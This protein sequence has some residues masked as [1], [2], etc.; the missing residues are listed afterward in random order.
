[1]RGINCMI[2]YYFQ[3]YND[4]ITQQQMQEMNYMSNGSQ[5]T[6][7]GGRGGPGGAPPGRGAPRGAPAPRAR[8]S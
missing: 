1:M 8:Y 6:R 7:G 3:E 4:E 2:V 5:P